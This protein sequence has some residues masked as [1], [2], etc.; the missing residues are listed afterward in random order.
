MVLKLFVLVACRDSMGSTRPFKVLVERD[1]L[2]A[3]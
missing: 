1:I 2:G 3:G